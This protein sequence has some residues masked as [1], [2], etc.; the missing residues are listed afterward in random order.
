MSDAP[1][2]TRTTSGAQRRAFLKGV[3]AAA[4]LAAVPGAMAS[5]QV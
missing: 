2:E 5:T 1:K 3:S 4:G